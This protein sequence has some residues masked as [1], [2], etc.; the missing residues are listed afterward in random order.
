MNG[1][2]KNA[3]HL[4]SPKYRGQ[5]LSLQSPANA[6]DPSLGSV[7]EVLYKKHPSPGQLTPEAILLEQTPVP[8]HEPHF[9]IFDHLDGNLIRRIALRTT[10]AAGPSGID[11]MGWRRLCSS[12]K[13]SVSLCHAL[14]AIA[15]YI[16][17]SYVDPAGLSAFVACRLIA[18][19]KNPGVRPIGIGE[20]SRRIICKAILNILHYDILDVTGVEQLCTGIDSGCEAAAH[21][22]RNM[23]NDEGIEGLLLVDASNA[24]NLLNRKVALRNIL[25]LC[26]SFGRALVNTYRDDTQLFIGG[27]TIMSREGATQGD[28][29]AMAMYALASLPLI[30]RI[31][32]LKSVKQVW[33]ADDCTAGGSLEDIHQWWMKL[34]NLGPQYG[35]Y[36]NPVKTILLVKPNHYN[37]AKCLFDGCGLTIT[38][39]GAVALRTPI[40]TPAF[41]EEK[42][43]H[44][45]DSW[46]R[47]IDQLS[48]IALSQPQSAFAALTHGLMSSWN[49]ILRT[50]PNIAT[51]LAPLENA[52]RTKLIPALTGQGAPND[53]LRELF[54]LPC[55]M[56]GLGI[57]DPSQQSPIYHSNSLKVTAPIVDLLLCQ[58]NT[59]TYHTLNAQ[60]EAKMTIRKIKG[61]S[62]KAKFTS[63][64]SR[65]TPALKKLIDITSEKGASTWLSVLPLRCHDYDLNKGSFRDSLCL[66]YGW[67]HPHL[68]KT[69]V[70]GEN[71]SV[72]HALNCPCGGLPSLRHN[73]L[74]DIT[75]SLMKHVCPQVT[76]EPCLQPLSGETLEPQSAIKDDNARSDIRAEGFWNSTHQSAFF[77][78]KVFNPIART[79]CKQPLQTCYRNLENSKRR[80]YQ[81]RIINIEHGSFAPLVFSCAG[82]IGPV[83]TTVYHRLASM[84]SM[85][86]DD[87]YSRTMLYIRTKLGFALQRSAIRCIRGTR[88]TFRQDLS[89]INVDLALTK[90]KVAY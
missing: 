32:P 85:K 73:E 52:L 84:M 24:F 49:Y 45:V 40:G 4:L 36:P 7:R 18:L 9:A 80:N 35:Y 78:I 47:E 37:K 90:G 16:C 65:L 48:T 75:A 10:G 72:S 50:C 6:N 51:H 44:K 83:A 23:S 3:L 2:I 87:N 89:T 11:A 26:P 54:S 66:R 77:D 17:T 21:T 30:R 8:N 61:S 28:P 57:L 58:S 39:E 38:T 76:T 64:R 68:P 79:Y 69:C 81:D 34:T 70:C 88:S 55:R 74:R 42:I 86:Y 33:Y 31:D 15:R 22:I 67:D 20:T 56:G 43:I 19:D 53:I 14:A 63:I 82:G 5:P 71:F 12:F 1:Q 25:A 41:V 29:M 27:K 46:I 13:A 60:A 59:F 62:L